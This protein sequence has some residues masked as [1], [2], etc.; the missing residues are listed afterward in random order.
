MK[1]KSLMTHHVHTCTPEDTLAHAAKLM[2]DHDVGSIV[3]VDAEGRAIAMITDRD[4]C[5]AAYTQ[6]V[7]LADVDVAMAMSRD[8]VTCTPDTSVSEV[9]TMMRN[10]QLRRIPVVGYGDELV[11]IVTLGDLARHSQERTLAMALESPALSRTFAGIVSPR[12]S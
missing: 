3:V 8:I 4:A 2:W 12:P 9:E 10:A 11:G 6:G 7:R 5:M 1:V